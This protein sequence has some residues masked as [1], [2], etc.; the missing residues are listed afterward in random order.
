MFLYVI[1]EYE[2]EIYYSFINILNEPN[3]NPILNVNLKSTILYTLYFI[4]YI[5]EKQIKL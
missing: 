3:N 4:F 2:K 1:I 5:T